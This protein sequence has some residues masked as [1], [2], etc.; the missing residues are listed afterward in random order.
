MPGSK[1][2]PWYCGSA[3]L[4]VS[5]CFLGGVA[6]YCRGVW[7]AVAACLGNVSLPVYLASLLVFAGV[8][9]C[10]ARRLTLFLHFHA[11]NIPFHRV[12][13]YNLLALFV[14]IFLPSSLGGDAVK[15]YCLHQCSGRRPE[16]FGLVILDRLFGLLC[17]VALSG[18]ALIFSGTGN[19]PVNIRV[20]IYIMIVVSVLAVLFLLQPGITEM[21]DRFLSSLLPSRFTRLPKSIH[22][23][24]QL[25]RYSGGIV[26]HAFYLSLGAQSFYILNYYLIARSLGLD[27]PLTFF[28]FFVPLN[29]ILGL[30]PSVNGLGVREAAYLFYASEQLGSGEALALSLLS[31][32]TLFLAG[33][34]GGMI[35]LSSGRHGAEV[36]IEKFQRK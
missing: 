32:F 35:Y 13:N 36:N 30:L 31:T 20:T 14:N 19:L 21:A 2:P 26:R 4:A 11:I 16:V 17:L 6:F 24:M 15:A 27:L 29:V 25:F 28:V 7:P 33:C 10:N 8:I 23:A 9:A 22:Q 18:T 12:L 34:L 5:L 1:K 3:R